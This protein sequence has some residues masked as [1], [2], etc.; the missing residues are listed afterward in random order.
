MNNLMEFSFPKSGTKTQK[1]LSIIDVAVQ[2]QN[3]LPGVPLKY[4]ISGDVIEL[5]INNIDTSTEDFRLAMIN[6]GMVLASIKKAIE[7]ENHIPHIQSFPNVEE[8]HLVAF[9]RIEKAPTGISLPSPRYTSSDFRPEDSFAA[10]RKILS[11]SNVTLTEL[12]QNDE[13]AGLIDECRE[14]RIES[15]SE[16][17]KRQHLWNLSL[18]CDDQS[19]HQPVDPG[20]HWLISMSVNNAVS[21]LALGQLLGKLLLLCKEGLLDC[22]IDINLLENGEFRSLLSHRYANGHFQCLLK[23]TEFI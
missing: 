2:V 13:E 5:Q 12:P 23:I 11:E 15:R 22:Q 14:M 1:L 10:I 3:L 4:K 20:R 8:P 9:I 7:D 19:M 16:F 17:V 18:R 6:S 21:W